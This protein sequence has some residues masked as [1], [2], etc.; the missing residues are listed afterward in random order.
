MVAILKLAPE[1]VKV[2]KAAAEEVGLLA[3]VLAEGGGGGGG[4]P[5]GGQTP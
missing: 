4:K 2:A 5:W 3:V 1:A